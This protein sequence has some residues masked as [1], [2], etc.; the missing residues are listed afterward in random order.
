MVVTA[1]EGCCCFCRMPCVC[2]MVAAAPAGTKVL[3]PV[4]QCWWGGAKSAGL[5]IM[6]KVVGD[7]QHDVHTSAISRKMK[8]K[9]GKEIA[10]GLEWIM[11]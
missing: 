6:F 10:R 1:A 5:R 4:N 8:K 7:R 9:R 2:L 3:A 11:F